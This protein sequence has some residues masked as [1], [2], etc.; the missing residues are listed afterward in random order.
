M[1]S[2]E[3]PA[4]PGVEAPAKA[5]LP[6]PSS[7]QPNAATAARPAFDK[8]QAIAAASQAAGQVKHFAGQVATGLKSKL[9][10]P[11]LLQQ[12]PG[13]SISIAGLAIIGAAILF[14]ILPWFSGIGFL[15]S[16]VMLAGGLVVAMQELQA[17]GERITVLEQAMGNTPANLR[18]YLMHP[19]VPP[20][21]AALTAVHA[22]QLFGF[23]FIPLLW[24][25][26]AG[27]LCFDQ[28][29][30]AILAPDSF[31][32]YFNPKL[33]WSGYRRYIVVGTVIC[34]MSL[35]MTWTK[36]APSVQGGL[37]YTYSS[38]Y[39][40]YVTTYN[41]AKY[42]YP[43]WELTG[44]NQS[45]ALFATLAL[46]S[47]VVWSAFRTNLELPGWSK[48][49]PVGLAGFL[50]L[51]WLTHIGSPSGVWVFFLGLAL[52]DFAVFNIWQG[53]NEGPYDMES[54]LARVQKK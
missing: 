33:A 53:H 29:K 16:V 35:F 19:A 25:A 51:W 44:R 8:D 41:Y 17:A 36:V 46:L 30:K 21:Y 45:F 52:I 3:Q 38:Y 32:Q 54:L 43:G 39:G 34:L 9:E 31:G 4:S 14:S 48:W 12:L 20:V 27:L 40:Q 50:S 23:G 13:R 24:I 1:I 10:D 42:W 26:A 18:T 2:S 7:P 5:P 11:A 37:D 22:F 49:V 15:W 47:L 28:Y 6:H